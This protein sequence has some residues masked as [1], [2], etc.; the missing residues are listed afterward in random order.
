MWLIHIDGQTVESDDF[1]I[2]DLEQIEKATGVPWS[3]SNP[4]KEIKV[5]K[6]FLATAMLR[7]GKSNE[8]VAAAL[9]TVTLGTI[10]NAFDYKPDDAA[11]EGGDPLGRSAKT[12]RG[13]SRGRPLKGGSRPLPDESESV[14]S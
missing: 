10:K 3:I 6:A 1:L 13:S 2:E 8:E 9:K 12:T 11:S 7:I 4:L 5:A 14:T